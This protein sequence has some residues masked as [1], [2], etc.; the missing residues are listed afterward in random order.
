M[1]FFL[2]TLKIIVLH[3]YNLM[4][5]FLSFI[6]S[7]KKN[8]AGEIVLITGAGSG[9]GRL[10]ALKFAQLGA[11]LVLWD[12]NLEGIKETA[13]LARKIG[14]VRVHDYIC[15]C[16]KRQEIYQVADQVK[17]EVGDVGILINNA[18]IITGRMFL[19]SPDMLLEKSIQ[20]NTMA[21]FWTVKAFVPAMVASNHGHVV[22]I[23][24]AAGCYAVNKMADYCTSKFA[25]LGFA[26]SLALE[27]MVMKKNGVKST[28][29]CPY[30]VNTGMFE[31]CKTKWSHFLPIIDPEYAVERIVSGILRNERYI[32]I[33]R[34]LYLINVIKS[35]TPAKS[36][37]L[38]YDYLGIL[39]VMNKFKG[40]TE[41]TDDYKYQTKSIKPPGSLD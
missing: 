14:T 37:D 1:N 10:M 3:I 25:V 13:R 15:D 38:F 9:M 22:T 11:T 36:A 20:V 19:D 41:K 29:V 30:L 31:G 40:R 26:E 21:H 17:K 24:S 32:F 8:V 39:Q 28:I 4:E 34:S 5:Y 33:P 7:R 2:E 12:V 27:M 23:S 18:G 16:S 6:Y 35:I